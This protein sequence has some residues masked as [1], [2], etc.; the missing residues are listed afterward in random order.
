M[1]DVSASLLVICVLRRILRVPGSRVARSDPG[2]AAAPRLEARGRL[3]RRRRPAVGGGAGRGVGNRWMYGKVGPGGTST[4][5]VEVVEAGMPAGP[6][7]FFRLNGYFQGPPRMVRADRG[8][9]VREVL[10]N[11]GQEY[12]W[13]LLGAPVGPTW[14]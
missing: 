2:A 4:W 6:W 3:G 11:S 1:T 5:K 8:G 10:P 13:Y 7:P 12:L 14:Q 9:S